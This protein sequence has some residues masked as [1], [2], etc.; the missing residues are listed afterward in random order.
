MS[1]ILT[2]QEGRVLHVVNNLP[3]Q[4][5][6]LGHDV[7]DGLFAA[8]DAA[9]RPDI[10]AVVLSGAGGFFCAGGD[11]R[12]LAVAH[13]VD[14]AERRVGVDQLNRLIHAMRACPRPIIAAVEGGA[15]GA[16]ASLAAACDLIVAGADAYFMLAYVKIG[17]TPDGGATWTFARDLPRQFATE[18]ALTGGRVPAARLHQLGMVNRLADDPVAEALAWAA[19][20]ARGPAEAMAGIKRLISAAEETTLADQLEAEADSIARALGAPEGIEGANAFLEKRR[21]NFHGG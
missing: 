10:G 14:Y 12:R 13:K 18:M 15:A 2:R 17:V 4:R 5:N 3:E 21:A 6:A 19:E 1:R 9:A 11:V 7:Y 16:G 20:L 8:L